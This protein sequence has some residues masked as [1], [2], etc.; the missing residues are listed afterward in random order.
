MGLTDFFK[1]LFGGETKKEQPEQ[2][3]TA[4]AEEETSSEE[5]A[6]A[7]EETTSEERPQQ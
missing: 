5:A 3:Q 6:P 2:G 4:Q 7:Q 1:K